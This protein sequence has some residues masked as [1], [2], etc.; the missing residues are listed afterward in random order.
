MLNPLWM[1]EDEIDHPQAEPTHNNRKELRNEEDEDIL[2]QFKKLLRYSRNTSKHNFRR[3]MAKTENSSKFLWIKP[4]QTS[5]WLN[6]VASLMIKRLNMGKPVT[7]IRPHFL[8]SLLGPSSCSH[9]S[10]TNILYAEVMTSRIV[11]SLK[12]SPKPQTLVLLGKTREERID[13]IT[14]TLD[15]LFFECTAQ[16]NSEELNNSP[17]ARETDGGYRFS[18]CILSEQLCLLY[19]LGSSRDVS[20]PYGMIKPSFGFNITLTFKRGTDTYQVNPSIMDFDVLAFLFNRYEIEYILKRKTNPYQSSVRLIL[21]HFEIF[22]DL[23]CAPTKMIEP[24]LGHTFIGL[25]HFSF[26][27]ELKK[28]TTNAEAKF[29]DLLKNVKRALKCST[30]EINAFLRGLSMVL[31]LIDID[32]RSSVDVFKE[33]LRMDMERHIETFDS[34]LLAHLCDILQMERFEVLKNMNSMISGKVLPG[35]FKSSTDF[36][37]VVYEAIF[38][39]VVEKG[40]LAS[41]SFTNIEEAEDELEPDQL[42]AIHIISLPELAHNNSLHYFGDLWCNVSSEHLY[43]WALQYLIEDI[44]SI[45]TREG[46]KLTDPLVD[47]LEKS[48]SREVIDFLLGSQGILCTFPALSQQSA[49]QEKYEAIDSIIQYFRNNS[50]YGL[51]CVNICKSDED[52]LVIDHSFGRFEYS[53][54]AIFPTAVNEAPE[55]QIIRNGIP[56]VDISETHK[57]FLANMKQLLSSTALN[58]DPTFLTFCYLNTSSSTD[59]QLAESSFSNLTSQIAC[60]VLSFV[61]ETNEKSFDYVLSPTTFWRTFNS[62]TFK[63][64]FLKDSNTSKRKDMVSLATNVLQHY[65]GSNH[66]SNDKL[67]YFVGKYNILM[68]KDAYDFLRKRVLQIMEEAALVIQR[69]WRLVI[70]RRQIFKSLR[71]LISKRRDPLRK[72]DVAN[73]DSKPNVT[74]M[75]DD[76]RNTSQPTP[77]KE[78]KKKMQKSYAYSL[79]KRKENT[80]HGIDKSQLPQKALVK[81]KSSLSISQN[82]P[83][84]LSRNEKVIESVIVIQAFI[85]GG[86]LKRQISTLERLAVMLQSLYRER[87]YS[88]IEKELR[89]RKF[90]VI[91]RKNEQKKNEFDRQNRAALTIQHAWKKFKTRYF[92]THLLEAVIIIQRAWRAYKTR[93]AI[94][95]ALKNNKAKRQQ[96]KRRLD[97]EDRERKIREAESRIAKYSQELEEKQKLLK[98]EEQ[99]L[100]KNQFMERKQKEEKLWA[101]VSEISTSLLLSRGSTLNITHGSSSGSVSSMTSSQDDRCSSEGSPKKKTYSDFLKETYGNAPVVKLKEKTPKIA[102]QHSSNVSPKKE[103]KTP[104]NVSSFR[105]SFLNT[106]ASSGDRHGVTTSASPKPPTIPKL[107]LNKIFLNNTTHGMTSIKKQQSKTVYATPVQESKKQSEDGWLTWQKGIDEL[108]QILRKE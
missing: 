96:E 28:D 66:D 49:Y 75:V 72:N 53:M 108:S 59:T 78:R 89:K 82:K 17:K 40:H 71:E 16:K 91:K 80:K 36:A 24:L 99:R 54:D 32:D 15:K 41:K 42:S 97:L 26:I 73:E 22:K 2:D 90:E 18:K 87:K 29:Y 105:K 61:A 81:K 13:V 5:E 6:S 84:I 102:K 70:I 65:L 38:R 39:W 10:S 58:A 46:Y 100:M 8:T 101:T 52:H 88:E 94:D 92:H 74:T 79:M 67:S 50:Y 33:G 25:K 77:I 85:R 56:C 11:E 76:A 62:L 57:E 9:F 60:S 43:S 93:R 47:V 35:T 12:N 1:A 3:N 104:K 63:L 34:E 4:Q 21:E 69:Q 48:P 55:Y 106:G 98:E 107:A 7:Q 30:R 27:E 37:C 23:L 83:V 86:L 64:Q 45:H 68:K 31:L 51:S 95:L 20:S 19:K 44:S 103:V 14:Q